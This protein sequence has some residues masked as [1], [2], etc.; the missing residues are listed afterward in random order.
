M[1]ILKHNTESQFSTPTMSEQILP[2]C[3]V[4]KITEI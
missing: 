4:D 3:R 1:L 2:R